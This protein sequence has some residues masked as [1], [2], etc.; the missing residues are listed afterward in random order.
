MDGAHDVS[1]L[2]D[3]PQKVFE[4]PEEAFEAA[5]KSFHDGVVVSLAFL[6]Y[7]LNTSPDERAG[8]YDE[9]TECYRPQMIPE[10]YQSKDV[11]VVEMNSMKMNS[12]LMSS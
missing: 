10:N 3:E 12:K 6:L 11:R 9:R 1:I 4:A 7:V 5:E 2:V 8:C